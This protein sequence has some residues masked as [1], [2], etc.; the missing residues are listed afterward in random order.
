MIDKIRDFDTK[1]SNTVFLIALFIIISF[2]VYIAINNRTKDK[3]CKMPSDIANTLN[4]SYKVKY[5]K[6]DKSIDLYINRYDSKYLIEKNEDDN[7]NT[8][9]L[10]YT[11]F[12]EKKSSGVFGRMTNY[13]IIDGI[14]NKLLILDYL[15]DLSLD[16][17]IK[18]L[19]ERNCYINI[20]NNLTMCINLDNSIELEKD[21]YKLLY[22]I[23]DKNNVNDFNVYIDLDYKDEVET[24]E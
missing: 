8:Y 12:L 4:Y 2:L 7:K 1:Y 14:D 18:I 6:E 15:N 13:Y 16:S 20:K 3:T 10:N 22:T 23:I 17:T 9:Y 19:N 11:D 21:D 5:T 24:V